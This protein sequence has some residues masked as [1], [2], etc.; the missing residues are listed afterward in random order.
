MG[1]RK[2]P[3][4]YKEREILEL[5][6]EVYALEKIHGTSA[7]IAFQ[8]GKLRLFSG[9]EKFQN[10][11]K[12]FAT[13]EEIADYEL[14][15]Q[16]HIDELKTTDKKQMRKI[17]KSVD[18]N[19]FW[20]LKDLRA[21]FEKFGEYS[22]LEGITIYGEAY[23]G[24]QQGMS[25]TYGKTLKFI[26]FEVK[27]GDAW[28]SVPKA[29]KVTLDLGLEFVDYA[30]G[31]ATVEFINAQRDADSTQAIRNGMGPGKK[32]EGV[33]LRPMIEL[34]KNGGGR[35]MVKHKR[36]DFRETKTPR[37]VSPEKLKV[38]TQAQE[39]ADEW[40]IDMR[41]THVLDKL[42]AEGVNTYS[43][44]S[45][46]QVVKAMIADVKVEG[47]GEMVWSKEVEKS[48]GRA[49]ANLYKK[50]VTRVPSG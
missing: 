29:E 12:I 33:V 30:R 18:P 14:R 45:T 36:D 28:L 27:I 21:R 7:H 38:L 32:R 4:L 19:S 31:P 26:A 42:K 24:R 40:V 2:I 10:F 44:Q 1:Y 6:R 11:A 17:Q 22:Q 8:D 34:K 41:M 23:G 9:G 15:F 50:H 37:E 5:F 39:I 3:N 16:A 46:G 43:M 25:D 20:D 49:A 48:I 13:K 35:V 47:E